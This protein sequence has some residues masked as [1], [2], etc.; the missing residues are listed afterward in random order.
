MYSMDSYGTSENSHA[1]CCGIVSETPVTMGLFYLPVLFKSSA[2][3]SSP[4]A[5]SHTA[6]FS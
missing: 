4:T 5:W 1:P 6:L 2:Q 3:R